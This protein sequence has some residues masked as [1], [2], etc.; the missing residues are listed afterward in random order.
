M[1]LPHWQHT[2][3]RA[4]HINGPMLFIQD[5]PQLDFTLR[6]TQG[7]GRIGD[8]KGEGLLIHTTL[9]VQLSTSPTILGLAH[10]LGWVRE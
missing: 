10:Q 4:E 7:L 3:Q 8:H 1:S 6:Q 2:R 9:A 5:G